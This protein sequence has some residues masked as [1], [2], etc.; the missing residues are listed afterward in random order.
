[1]RLV[2]EIAQNNN[3]DLRFQSSALGALQEAAEVY[4]VCQYSRWN[5]CAVHGKR[6]TI[7]SKDKKLSED[8]K[9]YW[10]SIVCGGCSQFNDFPSAQLES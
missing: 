2:R 9:D 5:P 6:V 10:S 4:L 7:Q 3:S 8:L 1:M